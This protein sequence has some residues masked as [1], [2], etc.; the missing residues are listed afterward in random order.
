MSQDPLERL[1]K[2][3]LA[4]PESTEKETWETPT[5]RVRNKL[6]A[7]FRAEQRGE[8]RIGV[9]CKG[10]PGAQDV[11]V[12]AD[13]ERFFVPPYVGRNGWIGIYLDDGVD[14]KAVAAL[15][16]DSFVMTAPKKVAALLDQ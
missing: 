15:V 4:L 16:T 10:A 9:W 3:C 6:F 8:G 14:W 2:I 13:P 7:M 12:G 5:F 1:R 11:L